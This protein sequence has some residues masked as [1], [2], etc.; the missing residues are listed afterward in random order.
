MKN[1]LRVINSELEGGKK[2]LVGND[3]TCADIVLSM[4]LK[5][6][7]QT[8]I[9][10]GQRKAPVMKNVSTWMQTCLDLPSIKKIC[11]NV[12]MCAKPMKGFSLIV[13]KKEEKKKEAPASK[14]KEEKKEEKKPEKVLDNVQSLPETNFDLYNF[15]T[16]F[17]NHKDMGGAAV[18]E[19]Y[20]ILDWEGWSFWYIQ[21]EKMKGENVK[22]YVTNNFLTGFMSR[23]EHT[24]KYT[25]ARMS[26]LGEEPDL[27]VEGVW[28]FRGQEVP[29]GL[30]KE[31]SQFEYFKTKK[32]DPRN[33]KDD[34]KL[35]RDFFGKKVGDKINNM[36]IQTHK[37][38]K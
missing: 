26:V 33:N 32:L 9:D 30:A 24:S 10:A 23:A 27:E 1:A 22:T 21:Y 38:H 11:G 7:F 35:V 6:A 37:W 15:K 29:D 25:F 36:T 4:T 8:V 17:V 13:E 28:L 14:P 34:D 16:F 5:F 3:A 18:D 20:K 2:F 12:Q 19:W 31:H